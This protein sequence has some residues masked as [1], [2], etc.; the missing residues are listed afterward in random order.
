MRLNVILRDTP[1]QDVHE[2]ET[3][4]GLGVAQHP[5]QEF[6]CTGPDRVFVTPRTEAI[7]ATD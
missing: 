7:D 6:L 1:A 3:F 2:A 4:L 5:E